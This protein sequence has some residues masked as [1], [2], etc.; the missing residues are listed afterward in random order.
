VFDLQLRYCG[1]LVKFTGQPAGA[2]I[3][4]IDAHVDILQKRAI[5]ERGGYCHHTLRAHLVLL[6]LQHFKLSNPCTHQQCAAIQ[7]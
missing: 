6:Q 3:H 4:P 2:C 1:A 7:I 5:L